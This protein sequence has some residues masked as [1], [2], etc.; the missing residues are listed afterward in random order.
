MKKLLLIL[1]IIL[2]ITGAGYGQTIAAINKT[3]SSNKIT[4]KIMLTP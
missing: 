4:V 2:A 1:G 3:A